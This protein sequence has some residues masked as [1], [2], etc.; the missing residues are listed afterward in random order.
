MIIITTVKMRI[1]IG[2]L[3]ASVDIG[4]GNCY[5]PRI[6]RSMKSTYKVDLVIYFLKCQNFNIFI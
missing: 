6:N 3:L 1:Y 2:F 5:I 4:I